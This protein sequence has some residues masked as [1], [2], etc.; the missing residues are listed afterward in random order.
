MMQPA[1][2]NELYAIMSHSNRPD[3]SF[4]LLKHIA[5]RPSFIA[6]DS[7]KND[8]LIYYQGL[9]SKGMQNKELQLQAKYTK[10]CS[11]QNRNKI[12]QMSFQHKKKLFPSL[13]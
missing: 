4:T 5:L 12:V 1:C 8:S 7:I 10:P 6:L 3:S 13:Q 11:L 2:R 9:G